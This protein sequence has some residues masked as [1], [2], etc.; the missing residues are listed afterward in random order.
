MGRGPGNNSLWIP[1]DSCTTIW[2]SHSP[3][4]CQGQDRSG[5]SMFVVFILCGSELSPQCCTCNPAC[6]LP[7]VKFVS[8]TRIVHRDILSFSVSLVPWRPIFTS[9]FLL[10]LTIGLFLKPFPE[11]RAKKRPW[12]V[13]ESILTR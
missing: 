12:Q 1:R 10:D 7:K 8:H 3:A 13:V 5:Q 2:I 4:P 11:P 9:H 6:F